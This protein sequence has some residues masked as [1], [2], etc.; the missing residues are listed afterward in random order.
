MRVI[1]IESKTYWDANEVIK[2]KHK[3]WD[4]NWEP[5]PVKTVVEK[6]AVIASLHTEDAP[7]GETV[8]NATVGM[9][10]SGLKARSRLDVSNSIRLVS[11]YI[12]SPKRGVDIVAKEL[13]TFNVFQKFD[14]LNSINSINSPHD[15]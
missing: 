10:S 4:Q 8:L 7:D 11:S 12:L 14:N 6:P 1:S 9:G 5:K 13:K 2:S 3:A 15:V